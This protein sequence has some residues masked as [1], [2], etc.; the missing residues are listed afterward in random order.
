MG[1]LDVDFDKIP[2]E[3]TMDERWV[4]WQYV[5]RNGKSTKVPINPVS[6][7]YAKSTDP[8]TWASFQTARAALAGHD[9]IGL[10][11]RPDETHQLVGID[12]DHCIEDDGTIAP[13]ALSIVK[14]L[15]S[16]TEIT[17]SGRGLRIFVNGELPP[18][19]R[20]RGHVEVYD[21]D[22][23]LTVTGHHLE[24]T[25]THIGYRPQEIAVFHAKYFPTQETK[26]PKDTP[27]MAGGLADDRELLEK[28][29]AAANGDDFRRLYYLGDFSA[30][31]SH[32]EADLALCCRL[33]FWTGNDPERIDRLFRESKLYRPKWDEKHGVATYGQITVQKAVQGTEEVYRAAQRQIEPG[34]S[35]AVG[36]TERQETSVLPSFPDIM[37]GVAGHFAQLY[38]SY[39][40]AP[41]HFFFMSFL[42]CMG[43]LLAGLLTIASEISTE[44]RLYALLLG[45]SADD[46]KSTAIS[47]TVDFFHAF[48]DT[49]AVCFGVGSAEGLQKRLQDSPTLLLVFD[50][51]RQFVSKCKI[52]ASVLLPCVTTLFEST[53]Y[54]SRTKQ[55]DIKLVNVRLSIVAASTLSTYERTWDPSFTDIGFNNRLFLVPGK[56]ERR[57]SFP[58][59]IPEGEK[60][61]VRAGL[62]NVLKHVKR[63][64]TL[65]ITEEARNIYH[66]WYIGLEQS[67]HTKRLDTYAIRFMTLLAANECKSEIDIDIVNKVIA[68]MNWQLEVRRQ[69]DPIDADNKM[70]RAEEQI[71]RALRR[72]P[73]SDRD[74]KRAVHFDRMGIWFF[75]TARTN[76]VRNGEIKCDKDQKKWE[77]L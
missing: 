31:P 24:G 66:A 7:Q 46:R 4:V 35:N 34:P 76:L 51:L 59:K 11:L 41:V 44:P 3:L 5:E 73:K 39:L 70:A 21:R 42:V 17:P 67:I 68:L 12:L 29:L 14:D 38:S 45:E 28:A 43:N 60:K 9:G 48:L 22:R 75:N 13:W 20:K 72:G 62:A 47:K 16:Y 74:L 53:H 65:G 6:R 15:D 64:P 30:H 63:H 54:E 18:G 23:F 36:R 27:A 32:S 1:S 69:L 37:A 8:S 55:S 19:G 57:F 40:E 61:V 49:F 71:R 58:G 26:A 10:M 77:L 52:E 33:A 2:P 56:G 25:A 50:E